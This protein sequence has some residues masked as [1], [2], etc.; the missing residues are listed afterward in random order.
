MAALAAGAPGQDDFI[1]TVSDGNGGTANA[2]LTIS[3]TGVND[4]PVIDLTPIISEVP[5]PNPLPVGTDAAAQ[6]EV[7]PVISQDGRW[8][9]FFSSEVNPDTNNGNDNSPGDVFL[10]DR[11]TGTTTVLT[12]AAHT[13]SLPVGETYG[14]GLVS[15]SAD[16]NTVV[17]K[18][19][20]E[21]ADPLSP[22]GF[23][24]TN[25]IFIYDRA[26]DTV[27]ML[28]NPDNNNTPYNVDDMATISGAGNRMVFDSFVPNNNGP[29]TVHVY[30]TDLSGHILTDITSGQLGISQPSDPSQYIA[31]SSPDISGSGRYLT[32]WAETRSTGNGTTRR[33]VRK[34]FT[35]TTV[36]TAPPR[37]SR[38]RPPPTTTGR[39]R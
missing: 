18:G 13:A 16:G 9:A 24:Q 31:F 20:Q 1:Y 33:S 6:Q 15:I 10:Y 22:T 30:V 38:P 28:T 7:A 3:V 39:R 34:R 32:F 37:S 4:A 2:H 21:I 17:F 26:S 8:V 35:P 36:R 11:L 27:R 12:D 14:N 23:D 25:Q 5:I 19:Q 29:S